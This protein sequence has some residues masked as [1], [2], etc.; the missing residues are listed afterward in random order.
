MSATV[1][2]L[3]LFGLLAAVHVPLGNYIAWVFTSP[4]HAR[5]ERV[6]YRVGGVDPDGDQRWQAYLAGL[7]AVS[8]TGILLLYA[9][10]RAQ[11]HLP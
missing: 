8:A 1:T 6:I 3:V 2:V 9:L 10:L 7:L 5:I 4:R 11:A